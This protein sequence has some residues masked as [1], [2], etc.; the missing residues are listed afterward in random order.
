MTTLHTRILRGS[1]A[2]GLG[3]A[4]AS[5]TAAGPVQGD[6]AEAIFDGSGP[7]GWVNN[8]DLAPIPTSAV[9]EDGL[10]PHG[11]GAY[12][13]LYE[14]KVKDFVLDFDYKLSP[15]CNSGV[16]IRVGDPKDPVMTGLEVALDDTTGT[17]YHDSGAFYDLVEPEANAQEPAGEWN[18]MTI[19]AEGPIV[20]V[21]INGTQVSRIDQS[22]F[23][24]P[25]KRP[26]GSDH[27]FRR[28][29]IA[30]LV[31]EGYFGFQDH[32][33]N[34]WYKNVRLKRSPG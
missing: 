15:G 24:E 33:S 14:Q 31:Q 1:I 27:K 16:F 17:G 34:V 25:G 10:N 12:V 9:Q 13:V 29:A 5:L 28:V 23:T 20:T 19:I 30:D 21:S 7:E 11:T 32:G 18:H 3:V 6:G 2:L 8:N 26:D 22:Q 4:A